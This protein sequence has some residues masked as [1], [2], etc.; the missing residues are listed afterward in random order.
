MKMLRRLLGLFSLL[1]AALALPPYTVHQLT[2]ADAPPGDALQPDPV[3]DA[4]AAHGVTLYIPTY[5][6][7]LCFLTYAARSIAKADASAAVFRSVII[8][9][10][11]EEPLDVHLDAITASLRSLG[12]PG[13]SLQVVERGRLAEGSGWKRQQAAKLE[14]SER[15]DTQFY[16]V[17]DSKNI[18]LRQLDATSFFDTKGNFRMSNP[19][20]LSTNC[21][22]DWYNASQRLLNVSLPEDLMLPDSITPAVVQTSVARELVRKLQ[23]SYGSIEKAIA[24]SW[25]DEWARATAEGRAAGKVPSDFGATE[26][27]MYYSYL[28]S[29]VGVDQWRASNPLNT[30]MLDKFDFYTLCASRSQSREAQTPPLPALRTRTQCARC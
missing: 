9:W 19:R 2:V 15:V 4:M 8:E 24:K 13:R 10:V 11:S 21:H 25:T 5:E 17:M 29:R 27:T 14:V 28:A 22:K 3:G 18:M 12:V 6:R 26:F 1:P 7:D 23:A 20:P 16:V 30:V